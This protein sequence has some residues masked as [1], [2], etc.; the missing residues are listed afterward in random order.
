MKLTKRISCTCLLSTIILMTIFFLHNITPFGDQTLFAVDMNHQY[1]DF[2]K[3]YKYVIEQ[4]PEQILYSFQKGIG[5]E[6]IQ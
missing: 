3:Y 5:G 1:I 2:F 4:A 6:M